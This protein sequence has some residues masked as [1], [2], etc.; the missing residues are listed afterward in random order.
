MNAPQKHAPD[1]PAGKGFVLASLPAGG[2]G[3]RW[4]LTKLLDTQFTGHTHVLHGSMTRGAPAALAARDLHT[5]LDAALDRDD[6]VQLTPAPLQRASVPSAPE[7]ASSAAAPHL[8][9]VPVAVSKGLDQALHAVTA[10]L[11]SRCLADGVVPGRPDLQRNATQ[12]HAAVGAAEDRAFASLRRCEHARSDTQRIRLLLEQERELDARAAAAAAAASA[13]ASAYSELLAMEQVRL[14]RE[15][16]QEQ[17]QLAGHT[18][19]DALLHAQPVVQAYHAPD[20]LAAT[21]NGASHG[22]ADEAA[23]AVHVP[24]A[25]STSPASVPRHHRPARSTRPPIHVGALQRRA[26]RAA[27]WDS[28]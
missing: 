19:H 24:H 21:A 4:P 27:A 23:V 26:A 13:A 14:R 7:F 5:L 11:R 9:H 8:H 10:A 16:Q 22:H 17:E 1:T 18:G 12:L 25:E 15:H 6:E 3:I 2:D 20:E 28:D